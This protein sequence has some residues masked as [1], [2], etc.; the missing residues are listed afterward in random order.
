MDIK[1][2]QAPSHILSQACDGPKSVMVETAL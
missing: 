1:K 2:A